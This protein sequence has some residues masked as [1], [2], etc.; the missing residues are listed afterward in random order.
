VKQK[1]ALNRPQRGSVSRLGRTTYQ[2]ERR[3]PINLPAERAAVTL[4]YDEGL[5]GAEAAQVFGLSAKAVEPGR[6]PATWLRISSIHNRCQQAFAGLARGLDRFFDQFS[7]T[8]V[9]AL[10]QLSA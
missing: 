3:G 1:A 9:D 5:S 10:V 4:V 2:G 6:L 8:L 7:G